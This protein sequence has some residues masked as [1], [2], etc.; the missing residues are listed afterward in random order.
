MCTAKRARLC[1]TV[2]DYD[3]FRPAAGAF[4]ETAGLP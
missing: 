3:P 1:S 4:D 2:A